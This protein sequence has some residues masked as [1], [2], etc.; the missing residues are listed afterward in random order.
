VAMVKAGEVSGKL[1][2]SLNYLAEHLEKEYHLKSKVRG[3]MIYPCLILVVAVSVLLLMGLVVVPK[4]SKILEGGGSSLPFATKLVI[5]FS[6]FLIHWGWVL[7]LA[8]AAAVFIFIR[9]YRTKEGKRGVDGFLL[10]L[11]LF[12]PLLKM[13]FLLRFAENLSTLISGGIPISQSLE[14]CAKIVGNTVY[15][16][17]IFITQDEVRRGE[18]LSKVLGRYPSEFSPIFTQ[19]VSVG[20][21]TGT[22]EKTLM[23]LVSFYQ[24]ESDRTIDNLLG[25]LEPLFIVFLGLIVGGLMA[26]L[27]LPIYSLQGV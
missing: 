3:A 17:I 16:E 1:S 18:A 22:L 21:R 15:Q 24:K 25:I 6:N 26:A 8:F 10:N 12:G 14:I 20:E 19:M 5:G 13:V 27:L 23:N 9:Y 7:L 11:P 2:E 4:L